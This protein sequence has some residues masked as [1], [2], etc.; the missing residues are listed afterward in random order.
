MRP[1]ERAA[2]KSHDIDI[3]SILNQI[4]RVAEESKAWTGEIVASSGCLGPD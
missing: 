3:P 2:Q 1:I 4:D